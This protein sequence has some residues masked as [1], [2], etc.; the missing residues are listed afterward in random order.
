MPI[1]STYF[2]QVSSP[3]DPQ[4]S[5]TRN[6]CPFPNTSTARISAPSEEP[7]ILPVLPLLALLFVIPREAEEPAVAVGRNGKTNP[8]ISLLDSLGEPR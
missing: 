3:T 4:L 6:D 7:R 1:S 5:T 8:Q 2:Q